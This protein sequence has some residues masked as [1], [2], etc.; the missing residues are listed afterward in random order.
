MIQNSDAIWMYQWRPLCTGIEEARQ[1]F[2]TRR[3]VKQ[4]QQSA[5][6]AL[7]PPGIQSC[8]CQAIPATGGVTTQRSNASSLTLLSMRLIS[9][10]LRGEI[11][12]SLCPLEV[13]T[14]EIHCPFHNKNF[15]G[16]SPSLHDSKREGSFSKHLSSTWD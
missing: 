1:N 9:F 8:Q 15:L 5:C 12:S 3:A 11:F 4:S 14:A 16:P 6:V 10:H 13:C 2:L 7:G